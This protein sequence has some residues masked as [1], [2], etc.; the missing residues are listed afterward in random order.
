MREKGNGAARLARAVVVATIFAGCASGGAGTSTGASSGA[1]AP[2][3]AISRFLDAANRDDY[4]AMIRVFGTDEGPASRRLEASEL[5][6]RMF[7]LAAI[8]EHRSYEV[9][10][11]NL[12]EGPRHTRFMV[13]MRG[14]RSGDVSVPFIIAEW[15]GRY[16][17]E[18]I[19]TDPLTGGP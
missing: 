11:S 2:E 5:E 15:D 13:D 17:V 7:V 14:T 16:L 6:Q 10:R 4:Q 9:R 12:R 1:P 18:R 8:L 19:I 3:E